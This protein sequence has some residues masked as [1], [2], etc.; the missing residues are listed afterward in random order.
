MGGHAH[1][2]PSVVGWTATQII[3]ILWEE[4]PGDVDLSDI[5]DLSDFE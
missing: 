2:C 5:G 1:Q 3:E 4:I